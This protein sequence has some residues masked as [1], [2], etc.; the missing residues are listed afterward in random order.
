[1]QSRLAGLVFQGGVDRESEHYLRR[2]YRLTIG[3]RRG[4]NLF[5]LAVAG[6]RQSTIGSRG[7]RIGTCIVNRVT[8]TI[9][10]HFGANAS[11]FESALGERSVNRPKKFLRR[12]NSKCVK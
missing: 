12:I 8:S 6:G 4:M 9:S 5:T 2:L 11:K 10:R 7:D 1:V 3:T